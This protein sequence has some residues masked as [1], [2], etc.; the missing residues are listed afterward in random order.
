MPPTTCQASAS[1]GDQQ[2]WQEELKIHE[3]SGEGCRPVSSRS[4][5][6]W[7]PPTIRL[8]QACLLFP[9]Q[10]LPSACF[11]SLSSLKMPCHDDSW[12]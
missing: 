6:S 1:A 12:H 5:P 8:Q 9:P 2:R 7:P 4:G 11:G 3:Q 10:R